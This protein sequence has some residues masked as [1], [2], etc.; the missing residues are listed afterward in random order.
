MDVGSR[1]KRVRH[2]R[3]LTLKH[4]EE[5]SGVSAAH[6]SEI[7]RGATSPT[8]GSLTRIA[9]ALNIST[10]FFFEENDLGEA[11]LVSAKDRVHE[12]VGKKG[13]RRDA[14]AIERLTAG[15][16]GG[17]LQARRVELAPGST[18]RAERHAHA[19]HE[20]IVVVRGRVR[21]EAGDTQHELA[22]RDAVHFDASLP[23]GYS[24][25]SRDDAAVLIWFATRREVD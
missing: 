14:T 21:V 2:E 3:G 24:N 16:P 25:A 23:H 6:L 8:L 18:Y 17:R 12:V 4:L 5:R 7:E 22:E 15:I 1:I 10:A 11:S 19:G 13:G 20:A 9:R